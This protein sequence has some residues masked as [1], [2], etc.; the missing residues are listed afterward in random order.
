M[1]TELVCW[2]CGHILGGAGISITRRDHCPKCNSDLHVC[3]FCQFY[4]LRAAR[5]CREPIAE[6]VTD[7]ERANFC[8]YFKAKPGAFLPPDQTKIESARA[9]LDALFGLKK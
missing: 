1:T 9:Q 5:A 7:K 3:K 2:K 4:D 8:D 6:P